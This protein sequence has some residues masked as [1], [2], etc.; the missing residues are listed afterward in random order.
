MKATIK[1][2]AYTYIVCKTGYVGT[3]NLAAFLQNF[4]IHNLYV[5]NDMLWPWNFQQLLN[6]TLHNT[7]T[8]YVIGSN[9][10]PH[11]LFLQ[12]QSHIQHINAKWNYIYWKTRVSVVYS[13][14]LNIL[15]A[16]YTLTHQNPWQ[17]FIK[18]VGDAQHLTSH[19]CVTKSYH[20][21]LVLTVYS[22]CNNEE[23]LYVASVCVWCN[24]KLFC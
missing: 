12:V 11:A 9:L 8:C 15:R 1:K 16:L 23:L 7:K 6:I 24:I 2:I 10:C 13:V 5:V 19:F 18:G 17:K 4:M 20:N 21:K 22:Y 14:S 3:L